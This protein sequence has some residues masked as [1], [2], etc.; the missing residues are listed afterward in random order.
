MS[1]P[2]EAAVTQHY[3]EMFQKDPSEFLLHHD[4]M[5]K[6]VGMKIPEDH[7]VAVFETAS[8]YTWIHAYKLMVRRFFFLAFVQMLAIA[9]A[10]YLGAP[11][12]ALALLPVAITGVWLLHVKFVGHFVGRGAEV[13]W[14][15]RTAAMR[16]YLNGVMGKIEENAK[17]EL[18]ES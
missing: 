11:V 3:A 17:K 13:M 10:K 15:D 16:R 6:L 12:A 4:A 1:D 7:S 14:E 2:R 9:A 5:V 18:E 8:T